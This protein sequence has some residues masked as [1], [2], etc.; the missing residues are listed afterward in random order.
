M[1]EL[2]QL[3]EPDL[4]PQHGLNVPFCDDGVHFMEMSKTMLE[5]SFACKKCAF[6]DNSRKSKTPILCLAW[7]FIDHCKQFPYIMREKIWCAFF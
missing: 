7:E 5:G 1:Y 4:D 3:I 6:R 2:R